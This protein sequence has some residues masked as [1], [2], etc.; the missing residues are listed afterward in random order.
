[1]PTPEASDETESD[2]FS[3]PPP[4]IDQT[5]KIAKKAAEQAFAANPYVEK[6]KKEP[7][8]FQRLWNRVQDGN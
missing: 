8:I 5:I 6:P 7:N 3:G 1:M 2:P 4:S